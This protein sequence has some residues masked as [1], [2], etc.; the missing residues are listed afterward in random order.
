M[1]KQP[2]PPS[3]GGSYERQSSGKL[4]LIERTEP[5]PARETEA[6]A[7]DEDPAPKPSGKATKES[8]DA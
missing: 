4:K 8:G 6:V 1:T 3:A 7:P 5:A 2:T